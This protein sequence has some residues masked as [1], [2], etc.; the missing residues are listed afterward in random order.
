M[1]LRHQINALLLACTATSQL[2]DPLDL[3]Y[4]AHLEQNIQPMNTGP[5]VRNSHLELEERALPIKHDDALDGNVVS[6]ADLEIQSVSLRPGQES[7]IYAFDFTTETSNFITSFYLSAN[8]GEYPID[9]VKSWT[10]AE[11]KEYFGMRFYVN[12][13]KFS[14]METFKEGYTSDIAYFTNKLEA[15][16]GVLY[17]QPYFHANST[18]F[19]DTDNF[20]LEFAISEAHI[21]F[22]WDN[23]TM[24]NLVDADD[25]S[26]VFLSS[27]MN[28]TVQPESYWLNHSSS[29]HVHVFD[30]EGYRRL[31]GLTR[32][33]L[34]VTDS[35]PVVEDSSIER[36][37]TTSKGELQ[38]QFVISGLNASTVY[39]VIFTES[40]GSGEQGGVVYSAIEI[41]TQKEGS[42]ELIF[43][44]DFCDNVAYSVPQSYE[45][46]KDKNRT[47]LKLLYDNYASSVYQNFSYAMQQISCDAESDSRYSPIATCQDC[48]NSY[49]NWL[50]GVLIPRCAT[51]PN[52]YFMARSAGE[53][54]TEQ[55]S[56]MINPPSDWYEVLPCIDMCHAIVRDC[57]SDFSFSCPQDSSSILQSY[58]YWDDDSSF[59]TCNNVGNGTMTA[60]SS[61]RK[62]VKLGWGH[63]LLLGVCWIFVF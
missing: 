16:D 57:P 42:C 26:A 32:S 19:N 53:M 50:C 11:M 34:A 24:T 29:I 5:R 9:D 31:Q 15:L 27:V 39:Y 59:D 47:A 45:F 40:F 30:I 14:Y 54:R 60:T 44:L 33:W 56:S 18:L 28:T 46:A 20:V 38:E 8:V 55:L 63:L 6:I 49:K 43:G 2:L 35:V 10:A 62:S 23:G 48:H 3:E 58:S 21:A 37:F 52:D 12:S 7:S 51:T 22:Q 61:G 25:D 41:V 36:I 13:T 1:K 17:V 4:S